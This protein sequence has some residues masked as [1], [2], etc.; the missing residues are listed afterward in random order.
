MIVETIFSTL[1]EAGTPNFAPMGIEWSEDF[2]VMRPFRSSQTCR[3]LLTG[4]YGVVNISDDALAYVR[5]A[6]YDEILPSFPAVSIPG[7]V[8]R[9]ACS[10]LELKVV[11][12]GGTEDRADFRFR[13]MHTGRKKDFLGFCRARNAVIEATILAT[14]LPFHDR[15]GALE[16]LNQYMKIVEK[17]GSE[18]EKQALKLVC[19]YVELRGE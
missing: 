12:G 5:C 15:D 1:N 6:L 8:F 3:N 18:I 9:D 19:E 10:W 16:L 4:G 13:I 17:T 14:R 11:A 2:V 7:A